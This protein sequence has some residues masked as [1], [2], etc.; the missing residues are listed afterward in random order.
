MGK[1]TN[2]IGEIKA[3][4]INLI[5]DLIR[6]NDEI[7]RVMLADMTNFTRMN[8]TRWVGVLMDKGIVYEEGEIIA[9]RGRPAKKLHINRDVAYSITVN[10]DVDAITI[11]VV[12]IK[13]EIVIIETLD[14]EE[15]I[16]M[17]DYVDKVYEVYKEWK[18]KYPTVFKKIWCIT[19]VS[20]GIINS[21]TGEIIISAQLGWRKEKIS[22]Y[23]GKKFGIKVIVDNDVKSALMGELAFAEK[24]GNPSIAYM[25]IGYGVGVGLWIDGKILRGANNNAGEIGHISIDYNG[26]QCNCG[27]RGCLD[28]VLSIKSFLKKAHSIDKN[29]K[30]IKDIS[31]SYHKGETWAIELVDDASRYFSIAINN[32]VYAYDPDKIIVGGLLFDMFPGI[33]DIMMKSKHFRIYGEYIKNVQ[34]VHSKMGSEA[35]IIG[36]AIRA[37]S[38]MLEKMLT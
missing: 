24:K 21:E 33:L 7:T 20:P 1:N 30:S 4:N 32:I 13:S 31:E 2:Y 8:I 10:I 14:S 36:G 34:I 25:A 28:T 6:N 3:E 19:F 11:A 22:D 15:Q 23:A 26:E 35:Y 27:R 16:S 12:N 37:K 9:S 38:W 5:F 18:S 17:E 29:I